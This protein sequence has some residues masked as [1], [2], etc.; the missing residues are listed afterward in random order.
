[1]WFGVL[2]VID[3]G[4]VPTRDV[5]VLARLSTRTIRQALKKARR[6]AW[7]AVDTVG[8][9]SRRVRLT[10]SR[11]SAREVWASI[12]ADVEIAWSARVRSDTVA[13][14]RSRLVAVVDRLDLEFPH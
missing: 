14:L 6:H 5:P 13:A 10:T 7:V 4:D 9:S 3:P 8:D 1:M 12:V 11:T 2:R